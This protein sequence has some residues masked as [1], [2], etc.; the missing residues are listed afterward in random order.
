MALRILRMRG[1]HPT[2]GKVHEARFVL[3]SQKSTEVALELARCM[4][5]RRIM[6]LEWSCVPLE[7]SSRGLDFPYRV[8]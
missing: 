5:Y 1:H 3:P 2:R 8:H 7:E 6:R 4:R